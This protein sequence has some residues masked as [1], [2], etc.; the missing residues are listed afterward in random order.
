MSYKYKVRLK[1]IDNSNVTVRDEVTTFTSDIAKTVGEL[2]ELSKNDQ[3]I[4]VESETFHVAGIEHQDDSS[5]FD[6]VHFLLHIIK[7]K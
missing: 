4:D 7:L 3:Y 6:A 1:V 2:K 5:I